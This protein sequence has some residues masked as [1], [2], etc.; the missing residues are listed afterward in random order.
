MPKC[1]V[2][3]K[4]DRL[5]EINKAI[6]HEG[7]SKEVAARFGV[8]VDALKRHRKHFV[9]MVAAHPTRALLKAT[10]V[11]SI[12]DEI[13]RE[14]KEVRDIADTA[15][16]AGDYRGALAAHAEL[17]H[18]LE[19]LADIGGAIGKATTTHNTQI[20]IFTEEK[21]NEELAGIV[22]R[23]VAERLEVE[24]GAQAPALPE[25]TGG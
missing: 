16:A 19:F 18:L 12:V 22:D 4:T 2:C 8:S 6:R 15:K 5:S 10:D 17:R 11:D 3:Q 25:A 9:D 7:A 21:L 23:M 1:T 13:R 24:R 14:Q 20:N